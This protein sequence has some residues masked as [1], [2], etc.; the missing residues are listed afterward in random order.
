MGV[1]G[2]GKSTIGMILANKLGWP[3]LEADDFH[4]AAN[5]AKMKQGIPLTDEDR[6]PWLSAIHLELE[7][8]SEAGKSCVL[9]CSALKQSYRDT[10]GAGL[11]MRTV[12][13]KGTY[14]EMRA[15]ILARRGHFAGEGILAGQFRDLEE[16]HEAVVVPVQLTPDKIVRQILQELKL[17]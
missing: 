5:I 2:S 3:F 9:G 11:D 17:S 4:S 13:L 7:R 8:Q 12:Y 10:L 1:T 16:P 14:E 15:H 6:V